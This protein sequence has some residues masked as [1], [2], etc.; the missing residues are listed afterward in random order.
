MT[1]ETLV[2]ETVAKGD[3]SPR[4]SFTRRH[5]SME[6]FFQGEFS[7]VNFMEIFW[8]TFPNGQLPKE[9]IVLKTVVTGDISPRDSSP[10]R[11]QLM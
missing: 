3:I 6:T 9:T 2:Q 10:W 8:H 5:Q 7:E 4:D 1:K 11:H